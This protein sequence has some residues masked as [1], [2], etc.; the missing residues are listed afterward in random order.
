[1]DCLDRTEYILVVEKDGEVVDI[2]AGHDVSPLLF[3]AE[4]SYPRDQ[5]YEYPKFP[6]SRPPLGKR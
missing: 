1:M 3:E 2:L 4:T 6:E 5:G